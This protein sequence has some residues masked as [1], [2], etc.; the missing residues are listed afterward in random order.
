MSDLSNTGS[1]MDNPSY[2]LRPL[3]NATAVLVLGII[4]IPVCFCYITF[5][6]IG[7]TLGVIAISL[8]N[9]D[10]KLYAEN[11][12]AYTQTSYNNLKGGRVCAII[13]LALN[14]LCLVAMVTYIIWIIIVFGSIAEFF[15]KLPWQHMHH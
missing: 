10:M 12:G 4:S 13:G 5:G 9:K 15:S 8:A 1:P 2:G 6:I 3:P 14:S 11:P 7:I